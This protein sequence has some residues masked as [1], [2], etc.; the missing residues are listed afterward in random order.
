[1]PTGGKGGGGKPTPA[2]QRALRQLLAKAKASQRQA[3]VTEAKAQHVNDKKPSPPRHR[4]QPISHGAPSDYGQSLPNS[5]H[6]H[7]STKA[8]VERSRRRKDP[9]ADVIKSAGA[10]AGPLAKD[11]KDYPKHTLHSA[12]YLAGKR[13][14]PPEAPLKQS[15][16]FYPSLAKALA[17]SVAEDVTDPRHHKLNLA[18]DL[19]ALGSGGAGAAGRAVKAERALREGQGLRAVARALKERP[20]PQ[21]VLPRKLVG[22]EETGTR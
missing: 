11:I 21:E 1:M 2:Q 15:S 14:T 22:D 5:V 6:P 12:K 3:K 17:K 10:L 7:V 9:L 19:L 18:L 8:E 4:T 20:L 16:V 13:E